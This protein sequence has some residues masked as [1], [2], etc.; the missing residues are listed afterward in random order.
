MWTIPGANHYDECELY[1]DNVEDDLDFLDKDNGQYL[2][3]ERN[4]SYISQRLRR[5]SQS[6]AREDLNLN[7]HMVLGNLPPHPVSWSRSGQLVSLHCREENGTSLL[8][9]SLGVGGLR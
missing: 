3:R 1:F 6:S 8:L 7:N 9:T 2:G 5:T 4:Y